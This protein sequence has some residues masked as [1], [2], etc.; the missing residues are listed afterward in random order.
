MKAVYV[1][2]FGFGDFNNYGGRT[3]DSSS[4]PLICSMMFKKKSCLFRFPRGSGKRK[5][6]CPS[7][8]VS[9]PLLLKGETEGKIMLCTVSVILK[10]E[11]FP[12]CL[13]VQPCAP[14]RPPGSWLVF[15]C[16]RSAFGFFFLVIVDIGVRQFSDE[17]ALLLLTSPLTPFSPSSYRVLS[18]YTDFNKLAGFQHFL[19]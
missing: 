16:S 12:L 2:G 17:T 19:S 18:N 1:W 6:Q 9:G 3:L 4:S 8:G 13:L 15:P 10:I 14:P 11:A 7:L 5:Q